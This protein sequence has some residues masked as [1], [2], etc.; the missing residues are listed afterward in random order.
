MRVNGLILAVAVVISAGVCAAN[1]DAA[2]KRDKEHLQGI[3]R[4]IEAEGQGKKAPEATMAKAP[5]LG[6]EGNKLTTP[7]AAPHE[8]IFRGVLDIDAS[9]PVKQITFHSEWANGK[10]IYP[11][12]YR[13]DGDTLT[14][15]FD[16]TGVTKARPSKF[17]TRKDLPFCLIKF[18]RV[19]D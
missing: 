14:I 10:L 12:I 13:L 1:D 11:G 9:T 7:G 18:Q 8:D 15:C 16:D 5:R 4:V 17:A 2:T 6:I 19:K 3:W